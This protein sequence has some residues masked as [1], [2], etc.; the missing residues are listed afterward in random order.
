[1]PR[2]K[3][4]PTQ[5]YYVFLMT[6]ASAEVKE[7]MERERIERGGQGCP[8]QAGDLQANLV[9]IGTSKYKAAQAFYRAC[10]ARRRNP[11]AYEALMQVGNQTIADVTIKH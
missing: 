11:L 10:R 1:M 3:S 5:F 2:R 8:V 4:T 9:H 7:H 6:Y